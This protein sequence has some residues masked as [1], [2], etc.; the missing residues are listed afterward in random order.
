VVEDVSGLED[1]VIDRVGDEGKVVLPERKELL[2]TTART[3]SQSK[4]AKPKFELSLW[5][6]RENK[7]SRFRTSLREKSRRGRT[8]S[9]G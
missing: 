3:L 4:T 7:A 6:V 5:P 1:E 2:S 8:E 9:C